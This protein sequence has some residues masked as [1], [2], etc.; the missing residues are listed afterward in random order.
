[1]KFLEL[2]A[3]PQALQRKQQAGS[4]RHGPVRAPRRP[5]PG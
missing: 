4:R 2:V 1:M 3:S 5:A